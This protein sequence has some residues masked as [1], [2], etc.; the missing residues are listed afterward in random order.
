M[1]ML[2]P[3]YGR[4]Q[5]VDRMVEAMRSTID[6]NTDFVFLISENDPMQFKYMDEFD[7][8]NVPF[9]MVFNCD[10]LV[11][12]L[13]QVSLA[14]VELYPEDRYIGWCGDDAIPRTY[15]W[16]TLFEW[17]LDKLVRD[18]GA[19]IVYGDDSIMGQ[20]LPT[21]FVMS[22]SIVKELGYFFP[23]EF[24]HLFTDN[25]IKRVGEESDIIRYLPHVVFEH[26]HPLVGKGD[27]DETYEK[28]NRHQH[29]DLTAY[30]NHN[31]QETQEKLKKLLKTS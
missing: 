27:N 9:I 18:R 13:N 6:G 3:T 30:L 15:G 31:Y 8:L 20:S 1:I 4:P 26:M 23:P 5:N 12:T 24:H 2:I 21:Y 16:D 28:N 11:S 19:G 25:Y 14:A 17:A 7:R 22:M 29:A 10:D